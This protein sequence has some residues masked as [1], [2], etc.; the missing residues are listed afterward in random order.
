MVYL[1]P[2]NFWYS[3]EAKK[4]QSTLEIKGKRYPGHGARNMN[5][6]CNRKENGK[7]VRR[8]CCIRGAIETIDSGVGWLL[9]EHKRL[10]EHKSEFFLFYEIIFRFLF[11][12]LSWKF[13]ENWQFLE[14]KLSLLEK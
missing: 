10:A 9:A 8:C 3:N 5:S 1:S 14:Q 7:N 13:I 6:C 4:Q 11:F 12:E 2:P